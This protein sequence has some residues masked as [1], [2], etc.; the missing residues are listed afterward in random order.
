MRKPA[1]GFAHF[2]VLKQG[3]V[4]M[5][6]LA[7]MDMQSDIQSVNQLGWRSGFDSDS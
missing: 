5:G 1:P 2:F 7:G 4:G 6:K 3:F